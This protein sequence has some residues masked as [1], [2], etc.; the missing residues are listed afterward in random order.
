M[1]QYGARGRALAGQL[2]PE[3]L[4]H[5]YQNTTLASLSPGAPVRILVLAP[6]SPTAA[7]PIVLHGRGA[8][9]TLD[10]IAGAFPIGARAEI[11]RS[12]NGFGIVVNSA[13]GA[14]LLKTSSNV[15]DLRFRA[16][17]DPGRLELDSKNSPDDTYRGTL[18]VVLT[19]SGVDTVNELGL[20]LY[21][22]GVV[23]AEMPS[24]WPKEAL[25]S[26]AIA[27]RSYAEAH[28]HPGIGA[29][30]LFDDT[31]N[32][33]YQG[34]LGEVTIAT[35]AVTAT[36][37]QVLKSGSSV[38]TALYHSAGGGATEDNENV[39]TSAT[40][41]VIASPISYL[42]GSPDRNPDGLAY[43]SA[44]PHAT[45]QTAT[46]SWAGLSAIFASDSRT[47]VGA[48]SSVD[49]SAKGVSGRL[50]RVVLT[51][52]LGSKSVSGEIFRSVFNS[53]SPAVDPYMWST[54]VDTVP[55]P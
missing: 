3:I 45:W 54:L 51:G 48:L 17:A 26:Q 35:N 6:G 16:G 10:G 12:G 52:S 24:S 14:V 25:R 38:I 18:R 9:F 33:V 43:D 42:R 34:S 7:H 47:N 46:Y 32:Q 28:V 4:A 55:I 44:S 2:A 1:S 11:W 15:A 49:L 21:L 5:Y 36:A 27:A 30:D 37:G 13:S 29:Y 22:R 39:Y 53:G 41:Q 20:D 19:S 40:G 31:R 23:P 50:I 8:P